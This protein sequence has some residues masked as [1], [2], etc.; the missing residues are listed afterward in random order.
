MSEILLPACSGASQSENRALH[1]LKSPRYGVRGCEEDNR[2]NDVT[3]W[4]G[5]PLSDS[6][7]LGLL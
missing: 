4:V 2:L 6:V 5:S 1:L 7:E 3:A